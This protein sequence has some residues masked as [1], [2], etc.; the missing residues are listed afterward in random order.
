MWT[1]AAPALAASSAETAICWGV[2]GTAG[3]RLGVSAE[4]VTAHEIMPLR[5]IVPPGGDDA[6]DDNGGTACACMPCLGLCPALSQ[7]RVRHNRAASR[8][9]GAKTTLAS[10]RCAAPRPRPFESANEQP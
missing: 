7:S 2:T 6:P 4:P 9:A 10:W 8:P 5:C 1:M 3:L